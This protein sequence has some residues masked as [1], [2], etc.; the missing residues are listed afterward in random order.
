MKTTF[1]HTNEPKKWILPERLVHDPPG[2]LRVPVIDPREQREDRPGR[3]HVVEVPDDV[4][5][6]VQLD[7]GE[8]QAE[9]QA[10]QPADAEHRQE[11]PARRASAC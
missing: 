6:V 1:M 10:G 7:V 8:V 11:A 4:V 5:G 2:G 3:D 9:R